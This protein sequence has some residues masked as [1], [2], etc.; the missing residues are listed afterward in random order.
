MLARRQKRGAQQ[1]K[2]GDYFE[3]KGKEWH[4]EKWRRRRRRKTGQRGAF[5]SH[6][7]SAQFDA[8]TR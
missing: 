5:R 3:F 8:V 4:G 6:I 2:R 1:N 7:F